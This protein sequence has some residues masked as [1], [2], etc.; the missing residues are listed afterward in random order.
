MPR[1]SPSRSITTPDPSSAPDPSTVAQVDAAA[2]LLVVLNRAVQL[3][4]RPVTWRVGRL[5]LSLVAEVDEYVL[6]DDGTGH[7][8]TGTRR[9]R[10]RTFDGYVDLLGRLREVS[11]DKYGPGRANYPTKL[12]MHPT[13]ASDGTLRLMASVNNVT[14]PTGNFGTGQ[15]R[16]TAVVIR[17]QVETTP[18]LTPAQAD[19]HTEEEVQ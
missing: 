15:K 12:V 1:P 2:A 6:R 11:I 9:A 14:I 4:L 16:L 8:P 10:I 7:D 18:G 19:Q 13:Q 17:T 5:G 3:R